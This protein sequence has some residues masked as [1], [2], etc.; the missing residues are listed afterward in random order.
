M[1]RHVEAPSRSRPLGP[2]LVVASL[3]A[4]S[5]CSS[6]PEPVETPAA[7]ADAGKMRE[8]IRSAL[9]KITLAATADGQEVLGV[10]LDDD[11]GLVNLHYGG[12]ADRYVVCDPAEWLTPGGGM[13]KVNLSENIAFEAIDDKGDPV[14]I[15]RWVRLDALTNVVVRHQDQKEKLEVKPHSRY[16]VSMVTE[17]YNLN[18]RIGLKAERLEFESGGSALTSNG[19]RCESS[20]MLEQQAS[21]AAL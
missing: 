11:H 9:G 6:A 14:S 1:I 12:P 5:A 8:Q 20:G 18:E 15:E 16:I 4:L 10:Q 21:E 17:V 7:E 19:H 13:A 3:L 2:C